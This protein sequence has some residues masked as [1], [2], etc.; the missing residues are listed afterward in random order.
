MRILAIETVGTA[1]SVAA[2]ECETLLAERTLEG[3]RR[4]ASSLAPTIAELLNVV[5]WRAGDVGLVAVA[6]GPGSFTGLRI[7]VTTAKAFAY[8]AGSQAVGVNSL[9][10]IA[11]RVP[12]EFHSVWAL[13]D[14]QR[15]ELY[16]ARYTH[17]P[18]GQLA[19]DVPT[20]V[21]GCEDWLASLDSETVTGPGLERIVQR[22]P[23][24][25][26]AVDRTLWAPTAAAVGRV[27]WQ[28]YCRGQ[29]ISV[30]DLVPH[31]YRKTA[32]EEKHRG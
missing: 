20:Q 28:H 4:A 32:A 16:A 14:A 15:N 13:L 24:G 29:R 8:A 10:S 21:V 18:D 27:G 7:G 17:R 9:L 22:L 5:G 1:G 6:T 2:L 26:T 23:Q 3:Q 31:Y 19:E 11:A 25:V 12:R 30:F